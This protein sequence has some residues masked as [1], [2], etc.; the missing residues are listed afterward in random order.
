VGACAAVDAAIG[1]KLSWRCW[2]DRIG[3]SRIA[4]EG[5][6]HLLVVTG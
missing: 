5:T 4:K 3:H 2:S 1:L 6:A